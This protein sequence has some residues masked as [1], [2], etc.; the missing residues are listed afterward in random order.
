MASP[1]IASTSTALLVKPF[2]RTQQP[3]EVSK[4]LQM[5][6]SHLEEPNSHK[7]SLRFFNKWAQAI[8]KNPTAARVSKILQMGVGGGREQSELLLLF[9]LLWWAPASPPTLSTTTATGCTIASTHDAML[10]PQGAT[11]LQ[12]I[13]KEIS[14]RGVPIARESWWSFKVLYS[15]CGEQ[16]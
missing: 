1:S 11:A 13:G 5:G 6:S 2:G 16:S 7:K 15:N 10:Q 8:W 4:I 3:Q 9:S 12:E 14:K